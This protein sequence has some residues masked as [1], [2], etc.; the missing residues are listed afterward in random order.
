MPNTYIV[1]LKRDR[2]ENA[3]VV[4]QFWP[5]GTTER[6]YFYDHD[7]NHHKYHDYFE[8]CCLKAPENYRLIDIAIDGERQMSAEYKE[9]RLISFVK[10]VDRS[11]EENAY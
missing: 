1:E 7:S 6:K 4:N 9:H 10:V 8:E 2:N 11:P 5:S 3:W